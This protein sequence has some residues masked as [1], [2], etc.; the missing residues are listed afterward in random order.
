MAK[1]KQQKWM[2]YGAYGF[3]GKLILE[4]CLKLG[5]R[6]TLAGQ[7]I[8][9]LRK[10]AQSY[11]LEW[12]LLSL[13]GKDQL[14]RSLKDYALVLNAAGPFIDTAKPLI[15]A[16]LAS[17]TNYVD[18]SG[19]LGSIQ[20]TYAQSDRAAKQQLALIPGAGVTPLLAD[21]LVQKVLVAQREFDPQEI[22]LHVAVDSLRKRSLGT[23]KSTMKMLTR[24]GMIYRN[25]VPRQEAIGARLKTL[26]FAGNKRAM[27]SLPRAELESLHRNYQF[28]NIVAF[29][30][31][32]RLASSALRSLRSDTQK[33]L[34][35]AGEQLFHSKV[36]KRVFAPP[37][38]ELRSSQ[39][40]YAWCSLKFGEK[41]I[42][43]AMVE[44]ID[45]YEFTAIATAQTVAVL[46][47]TKAAGASAGGT[48]SAAALLGPDFL[49]RL[50]ETVYFGP[51]FLPDN[52]KSSQG[53][54]VRCSEHL[55]DKAKPIKQPVS[56]S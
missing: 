19:E 43:E 32:P 16:C 9:R 6:P 12:R 33:I 18:I 38:P 17:G 10:L 4:Q 50:P 26:K 1:V 23:I 52:D 7:S 41:I 20:Y 40:S 45:G 30:V 46:L 15:E 53:D 34:K 47:K 49:S 3:T 31:Q 2:L 24:P 56:L 5:L 14:A 27:V 29:S 28:Q 55:G 36:A 25:G 42:S 8:A 37:T 48:Q 21:C 54:A 22:S 13:D 39:H 51:Q 11:E 35:D 44:T